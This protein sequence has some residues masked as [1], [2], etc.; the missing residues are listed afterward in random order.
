MSSLHGMNVVAGT[1]RGGSGRSFAA[2]GPADGRELPGR[3]AFASPADVDDCLRAA[4]VAA[5]AFAATTGADR[6]R[7]LEAIAEEILGLGDA[8]LER[9]GL[10]TALPA[11]RLTGERGRTVG[12]LR[13]F[14]EMARDGSWVDARIDRALPDRQPLPRPDLRRLKRPLG[15][16]VVFGSSNFPLAFSVAGGDTA[17]ALCTGNPVVVKAHRA[18]PGTSEL[19]AGAIA[20]AVATCGLPAGIFSMLHGEG[21]VIGMALVRHPATRA[22]G[23]T[24]SRAAG[25][26]LCDAAAGRSD[27]IPV[28]AEMSSLNPVFILPRALETRTKQIADGFVASMTLGVGQFCTKPGIVFAVDGPDL[29]RF[30]GCVAEAVAAAPVGTMLHADIRGEFE[31]GRDR[32][33]GLSGTAVVARATAAADP[34]R[35]QAAAVVVETDA[36]T[37]LGSEACGEEVFGPYSL[38]VPAGTAADLRTLAAALDGQ[39]T[40]TVHGTPED[41]TAADD[42]LE[43]LARKAGRLIVNGFPTGVEV[44]HAMQHGGPAPATSDSRFTSVGS[45][46]LERFI[47]PVCYQDV[48]DALLPPALRDGNPLGIERLV[49]GVRGRH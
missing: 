9:A 28:F 38:I 13:L 20:R 36:R 33:L 6:A 22:V 44:C 40:A 15:P 43:I 7:L 30:R 45:A 31:H 27:P 41:L 46:A 35:T 49:D 42:L 4:E 24:G 16:V 23:F 29:S 48:P 2:I 37:F 26:A 19:V 10:E 34:L 39:L 3:F 8:L 14:A 47:R 5:P 25:R 21:S 18:H 17:S 1:H 11:A 12:Q 32:M